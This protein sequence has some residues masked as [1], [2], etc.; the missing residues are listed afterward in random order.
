MIITW[1]IVQL[2]RNTT[3]GG[4]TTAHWRVDVVDESHSAS[5][6]GTVGFT[7]DAS[8]AD[9]VPY[10]S[11]RE[12]DVLNWVWRVVDKDMTEASLA[13]QIEFKKNP[14]TLKGLPW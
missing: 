4:V 2:N 13:Q 3:D 12:V 1:G 8:A 9:F 7:P 5:E 10:N 11:L 14:V 6:Y